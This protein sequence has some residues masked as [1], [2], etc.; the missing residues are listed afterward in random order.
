MDPLFLE[1]L[2]NVIRESVRP[3]LVQLIV[4]FLIDRM[5]MEMGDH[6]RNGQEITYAQALQF[7][8]HRIPQ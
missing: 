8:N 2:T 4:D 7:L 3:E 6:R 1:A 5:H